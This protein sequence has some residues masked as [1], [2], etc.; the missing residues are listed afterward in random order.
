MDTEVAGVLK[1]GEAE[2]MA[3]FIGYEQSHWGWNEK[4]LSV[5]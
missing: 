3:Y 4:F 5:L 2:E 1:E